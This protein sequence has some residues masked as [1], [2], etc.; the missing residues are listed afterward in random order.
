MKILVTGAAGYL[1]RGIVEQL[2]K[3]KNE[4]VATDLHL[5]DISNDAVKIEADLFSID[6]PYNFFEKPDVL[7]HLAWRDGFVH[8]SQAHIQDL[9]KHVIFLEKIFA[10]NI[11]QIAV[12]G[13]MHEIGFFE[14]SINEFTATEPMNF[15]GIAKDSLRN[16]ANFMAKEHDKKFQ[17][18]RAFYIVGNTSSGSSIFSKIV[19]SVE[20]GK[21]TFP[22]TMGKNQYDFLDYDDFCIKVSSA[23]E[24]EQILGTINICSGQ[25][26]KL[27]ERVERFIKENDFNISLEYGVFPDRKYDSKAVWGN[28]KKIDEIMINKKIK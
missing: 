26:M 17:W 3:N 21:T 5:D 1:G 16:F 10:S 4:V 15:Y 24:Q 11:R 7:L 28:S 12:M 25:P 2:L 13:S 23:V 18:L 19:E 22:F 6:D 8:N 9:S 20:N 14:G 27:S